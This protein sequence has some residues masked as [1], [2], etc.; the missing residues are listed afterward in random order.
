MPDTRDI[1]LYLEG[2][3]SQAVRSAIAS[4]E[5]PDVAVP[6]TAIERPKDTG[7]TTQRMQADILR[8]LDM[9]I[10]AAEQNAQQSR[11][12]SKPGQ[13]E[14]DRQN[15]P[16]QQQ[17]RSPGK[18]SKAPGEPGDDSGDRPQGNDAVLNPDPG[19]RA[20]AWGSLP[21]R[22]RDALLQGNE[23]KYSSLYQRLTEEY[24]RRLAEERR[25]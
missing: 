21:A 5:L 25:R 22:V 7:V 10:K 16:S 6:G 20:A 1:R 11:S 14:K 8:K 23:D 3:L 17:G 13:G 9:L 4:G 19:A 24:Y 18:P 15:Q 12:K 2:L